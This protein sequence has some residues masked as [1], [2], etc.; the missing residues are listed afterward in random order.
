[1][2]EL[3]WP[4]GYPLSLLLMVIAAIIPFVYFR[5]KGWL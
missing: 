2:P 5:R 1:M 3:D 4:I